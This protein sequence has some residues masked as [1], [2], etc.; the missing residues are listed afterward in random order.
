ME[1]V[2]DCVDKTGSIVPKLLVSVPFAQ[3]TVASL[4]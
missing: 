2:S 1:Y 3:Y 4:R